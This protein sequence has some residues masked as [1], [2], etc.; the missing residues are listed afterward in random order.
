MVY[1]EQAEQSVGET[2]KF[3]KQTNVDNQEDA[4][5]YKK[6]SMKSQNQTSRSLENKLQEVCNSNSNYNNTIQH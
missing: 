1:E 2:Q 3:T 4:E 5:V 6:N